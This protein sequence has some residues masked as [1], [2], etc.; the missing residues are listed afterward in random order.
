MPCQLT[1]SRWLCSP[2]LCLL[3]YKS[4]GNSSALALRSQG[5]FHAAIGSDGVTCPMLSQSWGNCGAP[6]GLDCVPA[7][8]TSSGALPELHGMSVR[9][10]G[11]YQRK[12]EKTHGTCLEH[13][14]IL[15]WMPLVKHSNQC[16]RGNTDELFPGLSCLASSRQSRKHGS[17]IYAG[18]LPTFFLKS[19]V[20]LNVH[21]NW[22]QDTMVVFLWMCLFKNIFPFLV[23]LIN[24]CLPP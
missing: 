12:Q 9:R 21:L 14:S 10:A 5:T 11:F 19:D 8:R 16:V 4:T 15:F 22:S 1:L 13:E 20:K 7:F 18:V 2:S 6:A 17:A 3:R 23:F 24:F